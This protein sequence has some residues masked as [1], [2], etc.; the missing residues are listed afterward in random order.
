MKQKVIGEKLG[1]QLVVELLLIAIAL[2]FLYPIFF[3][4]VGSFKEPSIFYD[5]FAFPRSLY[6]GSYKIVFEKVDVW[7]GLMNTTK[8]VVLSILLIVL[9][10]SLAGYAIARVPSRWFK[11]A[12]FF[13]LA[14][15]VIP[16][17]TTMI[18]LFK[19]SVTLNMMD[20]HRFL[21]L[22]YVAG[23]IPISTFIYVGFMKSIPKEIE[24]SAF[25]DG[26][27]PLRSFAKIVFPLLMPATGTII[28]L[29]ITGIYN[30][31]LS[32]LLY[33]RSADKL[34]L[35]SQIVQFYANKFSMDFGPVFALS[36]LAVLPLIILFI[37]TQ[38]YMIKGL[39]V[40]ALK[41]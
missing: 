14:G 34:T 19:L 29:N 3:L 39:V 25:I 11:Y 17:Q 37:F 30:D 7:M 16:L 4:F 28:I 13:F 15:M 36:S 33:L 21:I 31:F 18:T 32:P 23:A 5:P 2:V 27:G 35:M 38:K 22:L 9:V 20:T 6:L 24:E 41:G 12:Y 40:G 10:G 26:C 8:V 1:V